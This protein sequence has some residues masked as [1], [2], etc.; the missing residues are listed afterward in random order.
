[1]LFA[2]VLQ[3]INEG[4]ADGPDPA[5]SLDAL[6]KDGRC[7]W[8]DGRRQGCCVVERDRCAAIQERAESFT[9]RCPV[10]EG[11]GAHGASVKSIAECHDAGFAE[12]GAPAP[13]DL[14][15]A[16]DCFGATVAEEDFPVARVAKKEFGQTDLRFLCKIVGHMDISAGLF[17]D[18]AD[19][20]RVRMAQDV[21]GDAGEHVQIPFPVGGEQIHPF[22]ADD[23]QREAFVGG[24]EGCGFACQKVHGACP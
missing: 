20:P 17:G 16:L 4:L 8:S 18:C 9:V 23:I 6:Q 24:E 22:P 2:E 15:G 10:H 1:M 13:R 5:F 14:E 3:G 11:Q 21:D 7:V 12:R 19:D